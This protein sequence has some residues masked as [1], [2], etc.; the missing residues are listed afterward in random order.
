M[1][2]A[3]KV[4]DATE[5]LRDAVDRLR[6]APPVDVVYNPLRY[7]MQPYRRYLEKFA[8]GPRRVIFLG[9]NPGP[10]GMAQTGV[11]FGEV[12]AARDFL[13]V[14]APVARPRREHP[15]RPV[16]GFACTRAEVSGQR[17]WGAVQQHWGQ[18]EKFFAHHFVSNY[19]PLV[20]VEA[21]GKNRTPDKLPV[22]EREPLFAACDRHLLRLVELLEAEWVIGVGRFATDRAREALSGQD[23][24][25][26]T[27]LHPSPASPLANKGWAE[28]AARQ[29]AELGLCT[30]KV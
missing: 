13:G 23:T 17:L 14:E 28:Q 18:A 20:F 8:A 7:A 29:L 6:F 12:A 2:T 22:D 24:K 1:T 10:F 25:I 3:A 19:C 9:M 16:Q 26:G 27:V 30:K 15:K 11:P 5:T 21:G 4:L